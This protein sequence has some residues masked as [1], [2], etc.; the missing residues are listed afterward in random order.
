MSADLAHYFSGMAK[1]CVQKIKIECERVNL[2]SEPD[3][4]W[5]NSPVYFKGHNP[6]GESYP[7]FLSGGYAHAVVGA[8]RNTVTIAHEIII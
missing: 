1:F 6:P 4:Y 8:V 3:F 7:T 5:V 2:R